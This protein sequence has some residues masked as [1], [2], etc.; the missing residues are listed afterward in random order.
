MPPGQRDR[1]SFR[2]LRIT[3]PEVDGMLAKCP[4]LARLTPIMEMTSP[5]QYKKVT[6]PLVT[7]QAIRP[8]WH[9]IEDRSVIQGRPLSSI[10]EEQRLQVCLINDKAIG[11]L[12]LDTNCVG[13]NILLGGRSFKIV[14]VV[15]TKSVSPMF[16]GD[17][18]KSEVY[19]PFA[20]GLMLRPEPGARL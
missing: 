17:E 14:G 2:K 3:L 18:T 10:D 15:E 7:V 12:E 16:G 1:F 20:T 13:Q 8:A 19:I 4:S 5:I 6:K 11:E 9:D